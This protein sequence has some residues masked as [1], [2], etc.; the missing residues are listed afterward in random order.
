MDLHLPS[1]PGVITLIEADPPTATA[2]VF[3]LIRDGV[4]TG[5]VKDRRV[6]RPGYAYVLPALIVFMLDDAF[7]DLPG[8]Q[9]QPACRGLHPGHSLYRYARPSKSIAH[10]RQL[11]GR[12]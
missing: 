5:P 2:K 10:Q 9:L 7:R 3:H 4:S 1:H 11:K 6:S 12:L 8:R